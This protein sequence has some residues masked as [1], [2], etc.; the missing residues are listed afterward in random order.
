MATVYVFELFIGEPLI[1]AETM[2]LL[3]A[4]VWLNFASM[5]EM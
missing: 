4:A 3:G 2:R 5:P 1:V